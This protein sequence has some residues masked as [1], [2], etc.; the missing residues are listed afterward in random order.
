MCQLLSSIQE[1]LQ[2][3]KNFA[4]RYLSSLVILIMRLA[5]AK[6]FFTSGWLKFGYVLN[7]QLDTLYFLFEDYKVPFLPVKLAAWMGMCGELGL[8]TLLAFGIFARFGALGLI[9]MSAIIYHTDN[10]PLALYWVLI[11]MLIAVQ[12]AG[13]Y[14]LDALIWKK[15][16]V[17]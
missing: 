12:G 11:C 3:A 7:N 17:S 9:V 13:K 10:N 14:S 2:P 5:V 4:E 16:P 8:S 1:Q 15:F 6:V